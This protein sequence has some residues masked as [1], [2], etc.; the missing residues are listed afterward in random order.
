MYQLH[1][2]KGISKD[3]VPT[4]SQAECYRILRKLQRRGAY[5]DSRIFRFNGINWESNEVL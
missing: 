1:F 2:S 3:V 4:M 5:V